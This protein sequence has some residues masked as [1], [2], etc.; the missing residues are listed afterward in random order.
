MPVVVNHNQGLTIKTVNGDTHSIYAPYYFG[1]DFVAGNLR[2]D[3]GAEMKLAI[4]C[5]AIA[6]VQPIPR[7]V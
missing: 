3:G 1:D 7:R 5:N 6:S 2:N 4:P